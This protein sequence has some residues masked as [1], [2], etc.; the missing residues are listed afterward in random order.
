MNNQQ[1]TSEAVALVASGW[2]RGPI[3]VIEVL[4]DAIHRDGDDA[5]AIREALGLR[6]RHMSHQQHYTPEGGGTGWRSVTS[7]RVVGEWREDN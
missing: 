3:G 2:G 6:W 7:R 1:P 4:R 5:D